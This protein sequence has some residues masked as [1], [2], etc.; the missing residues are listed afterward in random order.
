MS[1]SAALVALLGFAYGVLHFLAAVVAGTPPLA[2]LSLEQLTRHMLSEELN[3]LPV[4]LSILVS[5]LVCILAAWLL[6]RWTC[7]V[8]PLR[9]LAS[10][11]DKL[12]RKTHA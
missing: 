3:N 5:A 12:P 6:S 9:A 4:R 8:G 2:H 1:L 10:Y 11:R 7:G